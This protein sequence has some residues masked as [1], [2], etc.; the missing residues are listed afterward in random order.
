MLLQLLYT[1]FTGLLICGRAAWSLNSTPRLGVQ[2]HLPLVGRGVTAENMA[3]FIDVCIL[4][5]SFSVLLNGNEQMPLD[6]FNKTNQDTFKNRYWVNSSYYEPG[7][8]VFSETLNFYQ[9][10]I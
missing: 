10:S 3:A 8:P 7:G 9:N 4:I 1:F 2:E 5:T 6:H